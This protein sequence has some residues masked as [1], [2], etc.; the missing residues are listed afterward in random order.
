MHVTL[1]VAKQTDR[2]LNFSSD[3]AHISDCHQPSYLKQKR[4]PGCLQA[5][6]LVAQLIN[7]LNGTMNGEKRSKNLKRRD[8]VKKRRED[9]R[10]GSHSM[11]F[12]RQIKVAMSHCGT[13]HCVESNRLTCQVL[14]AHDSC[15][16]GCL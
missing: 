15:Q 9:K 1:N 4:Y 12:Y 8:V 16:A 2:T 14:R 6:C 10:A 5:L 11:R 7:Q 13:C 3:A